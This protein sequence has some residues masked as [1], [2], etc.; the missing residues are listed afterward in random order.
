MNEKSPLDSNSKKFDGH[1]GDLLQVCLHGMYVIWEPHVL[2]VMT[3]INLRLQSWCM[4]CIKH[5]PALQNETVLCNCR[6]AAPELSNFCMCSYNDYIS[7]T[8]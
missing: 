2:E 3:A 5:P 8:L 7:G 1:D 6:P 4:L